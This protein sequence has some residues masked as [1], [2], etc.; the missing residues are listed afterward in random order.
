MLLEHGRIE[1]LHGDA[2][3]L[4]GILSLRLRAAGRARGRGAGAGHGGELRV[5]VDARHECIVK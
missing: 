5:A 1:Q 3:A 2:A 4:R